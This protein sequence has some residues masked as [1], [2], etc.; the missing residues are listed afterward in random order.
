MTMQR[1]VLKLPWSTVLL[2]VILVAS[3][4][5]L[6]SVGVTGVVWSLIKSTYALHDGRVLHVPGVTAEAIQGSLI[7]TL[8][9]DCKYCEQS[10]PFYRK[11]EAASRASKLRTI[12]LFPES[13]EVAAAYLAKNGLRA[14][15]VRQ[16]DLRS[17]GIMGT[18]TLILIGKDG[19]IVRSWVGRLSSEMESAVLATIEGA[20]SI[21][22]ACEDLRTIALF[23]DAEN[24]TKQYVPAHGVEVNLRS[25]GTVGTPTFMLIGARGRIECR[26]VRQLSRTEQDILQLVA[27]SSAEV[28]RATNNCD[29]TQSSPRDRVL[30][31]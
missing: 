27:T 3:G 22:P 21:A 14:N 1:S 29:T 8:S 18:P 15:I 24:F 16:V 20:A 17:T 31:R 23:P 13:E 6:T 2:V 9:T 4:W 10:L 28:L 19:R 26:W 12:A 11:V 30:V 7:L 5:A 25:L